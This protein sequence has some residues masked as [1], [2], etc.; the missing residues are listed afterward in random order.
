MRV[1][2]VLPGFKVQPG[3]GTLVIYRYANE[4]QRRGHQVRLVH[5]RR[6]DPESR[7]IPRVKAVT[8]PYRKRIRYGGQPPW[9][10]IDPGVDIIL[11]QDPRERSIPDGDAVF[12][13]DCRLAPMVTQYGEAKGEKFYLIQA[14]EDWACDEDGLHAAWTMPLHKIVVSCWLREAVSAFGERD[15]VTYIPPGVELDTF[16][17]KVAP[18]ERVPYRVGMLAHAWGL[19]GMVYAIEALGQA[20]KEVPHLETVAF[21]AGDR[22]AE[23]P[24]WVHYVQNPTRLELAELYNSVAIFLH[25]S[26]REGWPMPPAEA[27][28]CGCALVASDSRGVRDYAVD[29]ETALLAPIRDSAALASGI[30]ELI[31][32]E[33]RRLQLAAAGCR[34]IQEFG[35]MRS[36]DKLEA[37]IAEVCARRTYPTSSSK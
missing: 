17:V 27:L 4:L 26:L 9:F 16:Y 8:W 23:L 35:A 22:P 34:G 36:A 28:A 6:F 24:Q 30:I 33:S 29:G 19:K 1:T 14:Y 18:E 12:A 10:E 20:R 5:P 7:L 37:L 31:E 15:R 2:F 21:G 11:T 13:T 3:G 25:S 32:N